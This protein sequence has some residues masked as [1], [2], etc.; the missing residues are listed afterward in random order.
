MESWHLESRQIGVEY[1]TYLTTSLIVSYQAY[2]LSSGPKAFFSY[3]DNLI[4]NSFIHMRRVNNI[5]V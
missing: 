2:Y 3:F 1:G 4:S 5:L